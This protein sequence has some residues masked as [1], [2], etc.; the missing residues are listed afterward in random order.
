MQK[1]RRHIYALIDRRQQPDD[2]RAYEQRILQVLK[3]ED[4]DVVTGR[5][6]S[7]ALPEFVAYRHF[8]TLVP[9]FLLY[10]EFY[11]SPQ[12]GTG[13]SALNV[14]AL[15]KEQKLQPRWTAGSLPISSV[16]SNFRCGVGLVLST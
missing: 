15:V 16:L 12:T 10:S 14:L 3:T 5:L 8:R 11:K 13:R 9:P 7:E 4:L 6:P 2:L 1:S